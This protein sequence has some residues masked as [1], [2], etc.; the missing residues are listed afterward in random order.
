MELLA[1]PVFSNSEQ[2]SVLRTP[3]SFRR[4]LVFIRCGSNAPLALFNPIPSNVRNF[5]IA[6]NYFAP[7]Q[8]DNVLYNKAEFLLAG[9]MSKYHAAKH[10]LY[11]GFLDAYQGIY[12]LDED[13][14]LH[15]DVSEFLQYCEQKEFSIAQ[16]ALTPSSDGAWKITFHHPAFEYRLTNFVEVMAPYISR[17]FLMNIVDAFD[18]SISTYGLDVFWGS[19]LEGGDTAA[20]VDRFQMGHLKLRDF[21]GGAYYKYLQSIGVDCFLEMRK[22]LD[23]LGIDRYTIRLRGGA[24]IVEQ[25][26]VSITRAEG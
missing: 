22:V 11:Q 7:P 26:A 5:D 24:E 6:L 25:A 10:F 2:V 19:Q 17:R 14:E 12:F 23:M 3:S 18:I 16:A 8:S 9:G 13:V 4:Y 20:V 15:F 21:E 1:Q